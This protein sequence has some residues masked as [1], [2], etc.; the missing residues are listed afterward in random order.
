MSQSGAR[1][2]VQWWI[3]GLLLLVHVVV[4]VNPNWVVDT[5]IGPDITSLRYEYSWDVDSVIG[6][7]DDSSSR[8]EKYSWEE[9]LFAGWPF[10]CTDDKGF[11]GRPIYRLPAIIANVVIAICSSWGASLYASPAIVYCYLRF[12]WRAIAA[13]A[14]TIVALICFPN[15][16]Q[17]PLSLP[18][19]LMY[20]INDLS[21]CVT[22]F[23]AIW[24]VYWLLSYLVSAVK[25]FRR[26]KNGQFNLSMLLFGV[27][28]SSILFAFAGSQFRSQHAQKQAVAYFNRFGYVLKT[29]GNY[30]DDSSWGVVVPMPGKTWRDWEAATGVSRYLLASSD[31]LYRVVDFGDSGEREIESEVDWSYLRSLPYLQMIE[32]HANSQNSGEMR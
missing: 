10:D 11:H 3:F 18:S 21:N 23:V 5:V 19:K 20:R 6:P 1:A 32:I 14:A 7:E 28:A 15:N 16:L 17:L 30:Y 25:G 12:R 13:L 9:V 4:N 8:E 24:G 26:L 2:K 22:W 29:E 31:G 27:T